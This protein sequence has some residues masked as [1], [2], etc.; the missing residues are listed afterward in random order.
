M[1]GDELLESVDL[2]PYG[3]QRVKLNRTI[4]LDVEEAELTPHG[5]ALQTDAK[6][7]ALSR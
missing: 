2:S 6:T 5:C 4:A 7:R 3:L 1:P